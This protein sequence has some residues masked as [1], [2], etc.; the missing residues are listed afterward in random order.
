MPLNS[1]NSVILSKYLKCQIVFN[2]HRFFMLP[3]VKEFKYPANPAT[4]C[5]ER[6]FNKYNN[7]GFGLLGFG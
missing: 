7:K 1:V 6:I 4:F 2:I 3:Q 5:E